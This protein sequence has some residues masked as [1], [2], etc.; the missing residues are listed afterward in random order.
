MQELNLKMD[1]LKKTINEGNT[2]IDIA[3]KKLAEERVVISGLQAKQLENLNTIKTL[4]SELKG[5]IKEEECGNRGYTATAGINKKE[6][7]FN[8]KKYIREDTIIGDKIR[9]NGKDYVRL[10]NG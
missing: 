6:H 5:K 2:K 9:L 10:I 7:R 8:G 1:S 3:N 4:K